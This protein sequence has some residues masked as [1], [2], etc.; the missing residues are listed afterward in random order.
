MTNKKILKRALN[1]YGVDL[2]IVVAMEELAELI[3][4]LSRYF[5]RESRND[6]LSGKEKELKLAG[7]IADVE[8]VCKTLRILIGDGIINEKIKEKMIRLNERI[9]ERKLK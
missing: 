2:Q 4:E 1:F 5:L 3:S 8:I 6:G 7:E 9:S